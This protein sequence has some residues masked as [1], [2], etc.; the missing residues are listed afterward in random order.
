MKNPWNSSDIKYEQ[1]VSHAS[2]CEAGVYN[3]VTLKK[4]TLLYS[5]SKSGKKKHTENGLFLISFEMF[6]EKKAEIKQ[7]SKNR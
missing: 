4:Q 5:L 1:T 6:T 3:E 2:D 7:K